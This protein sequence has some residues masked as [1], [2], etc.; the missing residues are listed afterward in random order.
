MITYQSFILNRNPDFVVEIVEDG[1]SRDEYEAYSRNQF[2]RR[3]GWDEINLRFRGTLVH[4]DLENYLD[5]A[6]LEVCSPPCGLVSNRQ[7]PRRSVRYYDYTLERWECVLTSFLVARQHIDL[8]SAD[9]VDMAMDIFR[10][11]TVWYQSERERHDA[12]S[13]L[14]EHWPDMAE[15]T[16]SDADA[17]SYAKSPLS[18]RDQQQVP[19]KARKARVILEEYMMDQYIAHYGVTHG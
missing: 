6:R 11:D 10:R 17:E 14:I 1:A 9:S 8:G 2:D 19:M 16:P 13:Y 7:L 15:L 18:W 12:E 5:G 4:S 3:L